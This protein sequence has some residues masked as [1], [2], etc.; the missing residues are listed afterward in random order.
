MNKSKNI[1]MIKIPYGNGYYLFKL[2]NVLD[3]AGMTRYYVSR[4]NELEYMVVNRLATGNTS[5]LDLG[6]IS[7]ICDYCNCTLADILEYIPNSK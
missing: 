1:N 2:M 3:K 7:K 5:K 4:K 6:V